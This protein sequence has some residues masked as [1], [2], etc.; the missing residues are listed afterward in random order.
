MQPTV[1]RCWASAHCG[2][3]G[4]VP[5]I[6]RCPRASPVWAAAVVAAALAARARVM[7]LAPSRMATTGSARAGAPAAAPSAALCKRPC[8]LRLLPDQRRLGL[9][10]NQQAGLNTGG[11]RG[12]AGPYRLCEAAHTAGARG[13]SGNG[14]TPPLDPSSARCPLPVAHTRAHTPH[15]KPQVLHYLHGTWGAPLHLVGI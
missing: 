7:M 15:R 1:H 3:H 5:V 12:H 13:A 8:C 11:T 4:T 14:R 10:A 9:H 6:R 2:L